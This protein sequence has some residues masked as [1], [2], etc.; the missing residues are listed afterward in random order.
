MSAS[1]AAMPSKDA[2]SRLWTGRAGRAVIDF[3]ER[4]VYLCTM[5]VGGLAL[6]IRPG[7]W[8]YP[9]RN[10]MAR[11][12]LFAGVE[13]VALT[14]VVAVLVGAT[15]Y[16]QCF[17]WLQFTG[18]IEFLGRLVSLLLFQMVGPFVTTFIVIGASASAITSEMATMKVRGEVR[19]LEAQG[20]SVFQYM[21]LPRMTGLAVC[22]LGLTLWF[23]AVAL[24]VAA[25]GFV[26]FSGDIRDARPFMG[27]VFSALQLPEIVWLLAQTILTGLTMGAICCYEGLRVAGASTEVPQAVSRA[28]LRSIIVAVLITTLVVILTFTV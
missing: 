1:G 15:V 12:I 24:L 3:I 23:V 20:V 17:Q 22:V 13:A 16:L 7:T 10:R 2:G 28:I 27:S 18:R 6:A 11:Q 26:T 19:L 14:A 21:V 4:Q 25:A 8:V 9:V 5:L